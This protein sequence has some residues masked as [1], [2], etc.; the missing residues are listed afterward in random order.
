MYCYTL[1]LQNRNKIYTKKVNYIELN[2]RGFQLIVNIGFKHKY[3][4]FNASHNNTTTINRITTE[5][6][7]LNLSKFIFN[8]L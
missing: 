2:K 8:L 7:Y 3:V 5:I 1:H 6:F 4:Y